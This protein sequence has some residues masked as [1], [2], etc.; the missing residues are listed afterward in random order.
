M[1]VRAEMHKKLFNDFIELI[2]ATYKGAN[3]TEDMLMREYTRVGFNKLMT[4][5]KFSHLTNVLCE[6]DQPKYYLKALTMPPLIKRQQNFIFKR[7]SE[8]EIINC[9]RNEYKQLL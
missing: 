8:E 3:L 4:R 1:E 6:G 9:Y 5:I 2:E 7:V